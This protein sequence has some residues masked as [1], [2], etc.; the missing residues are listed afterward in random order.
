MARRIKLIFNPHA[1][2]GH[3]WD[4]AYGF[5]STID[6]HGG[7]DWAATEFPGHATELAAQAVEQGYDVIAA[8]GGDGT[9]HEVVNGM[10]RYPPER[11][12]QLA[13]VPIGSGNDFCANVGIARDPEEAVAR[14]FNGTPRSIDLASISDNT[15]HSEYW[16]NTI[17]IGF[18]AA[19]AIY[20]YGI[21]NLRGFPMYLWAVLKT[22][23][24]QHRA[25]HMTI[26][27]DEETI[28]QNVLFISLNNGPRE[29]GGFLTSPSARPDDGLLNYAMIRDVSRPMM[30]RLIPEV[31]RGTHERFEPV[32]MGQFREL[33][34]RSEEPIPV[35]ADGEIYADFHSSVTAL[36]ARVLPQELQVI[37]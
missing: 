1:D 19:V 11:R 3:A 35:H 33:R 18:G 25:P 21:T 12:P 13:G 32:Q 28:Q 16:G 10:M 22:I 29:G 34:L 27:T 17:S 36:T 26:E 31:M 9:I 30:F 24:L 6:R 23:F 4:V 14:I 2:R 8:L 20:A 7:G 37:I 15:G 5:H